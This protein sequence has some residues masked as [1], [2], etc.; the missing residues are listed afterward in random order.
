[1]TR[2]T[3]GQIKQPI[4]QASVAPEQLHCTRIVSFFVEVTRPHATQVG[5]AVSVLTPPEVMHDMHSQ[6]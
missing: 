5:L 3:H 2:H 1:M 6:C 4:V